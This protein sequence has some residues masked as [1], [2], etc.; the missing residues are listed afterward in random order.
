MVLSIIAYSLLP[1]AARCSKT[2][3]DT[4]ALAQRLN[5]RLRPSAWSSTFFES[6]GAVLMSP[7]DGAVDHR[8]CVIAIGCQVLKDALPYAGFGPA[9]EPPVRILPV[10]EALRQVAPWDSRTVPVQHRLDK[11]TIVTGGGTD[12]A[13]FAGKQVLDPFPLVVAKSIA[14]HASAFYTADSA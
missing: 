12:V 10:A 2:P 7:H 5:P 9:A 6:A 4:P 11:A 13:P 3:S 8:V 14:G 1:S